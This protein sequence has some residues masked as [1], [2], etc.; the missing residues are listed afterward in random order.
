MPRASS[1]SIHQ[2]TPLN[3][4]R[5]SPTS[6]LVN[7]S[8]GCALPHE[9]EPLLRILRIEWQIR[10]ST[11]H[12]SKQTHHHLYRTRQRQR[13]NI[14]R[15]DPYVFVVRAQADSR[16]RSTP[17]NSAPPPSQITPP[18]PDYAPP[19][20]RTTPAE[21][22][23]EQSLS[24]RSSFEDLQLPNTQKIDPP[25]DCST[26]ADKP[27]HRRSTAPPIRSTLARSKGPC[28]TRSD[29]RSPLALHSRFAALPGEGQIELRY[30][31]TASS[32]CTCNPGNSNVASGAFWKVNIT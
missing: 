19:A 21:F 25:N 22:F 9:R 17:H 8:A 2:L 23:P 20:L 10:C 11:L 32:A 7:N 31:R 28:C 5:R 24:Y 27:Y 16:E 15:A 3:D 13:Y 12:D 30:S 14:F 26:S 18:H 6:D 29:R 4:E 1:A